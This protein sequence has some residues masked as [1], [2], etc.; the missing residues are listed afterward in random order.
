[1]IYIPGER[2]SKKLDEAKSGV[3]REGDIN[4]KKKQTKRK[5]NS[6]GSVNDKLRRRMGQSKSIEN[7]IDEPKV[8][9][10]VTQNI[11]QK[12]K[13]VEKAK[14]SRENQRK[15]QRKPTMNNHKEKDA[16]KK[17]LVHTEV[18]EMEKKLS[19]SNTDE[20]EHEII[21]IKEEKIKPSN[22]AQKKE[23]L[24]T[25]EQKIE[26]ESSEKKNLDDQEEERNEE[27]ERKVQ[28]ADLLGLILA[29]SDPG[30]VKVLIDNSSP[31]NLNVFLEKSNIT[32][33]EL[34]DIAAY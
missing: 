18:R 3:N 16:T 26:I 7:V 27:N 33:D 19:K 10:E 17:E 29:K 1:L 22:I 5:K 2:Q 21:A 30:L 28:N 20:D 9:S 11:A 12:K 14:D 25:T 23:Q 24:G 15:S 13:K 6:K 34:K 31:E 4:K 8:D 32:L